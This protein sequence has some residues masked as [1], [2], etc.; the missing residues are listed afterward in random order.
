MTPSLSP[1]VL[2]GPRSPLGRCSLPHLTVRRGQ[3]SAHDAASFH[4]GGM[5]TGPRPAMGIAD[6]GLDSFLGGDQCDEKL[7]RAT[8]PGGQDGSFTA[9]DGKTAE[10]TLLG[11]KGDGGGPGSTSPRCVMGSN[12]MKQANEMMLMRMVSSC[13]TSPSELILRG[14]LQT[15]HKEQL[16]GICGERGKKQRVE[17]RKREK[18]V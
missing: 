12:W 1:S 17:G 7:S 2:Q 15:K 6:C 8:T 13:R 9:S 5:S 3:P 14:E 4:S 10:E 18:G 16:A 11:V